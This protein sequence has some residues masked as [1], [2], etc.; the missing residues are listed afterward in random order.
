ML[1][2]ARL[3][4]G[5]VHLVLDRPVRPLTVPHPPSPPSPGA[6]GSKNN[7][8]LLLPTF[9]VG[10]FY[11]L[12][13]AFCFQNSSCVILPQSERRGRRCQ[14]ERKVEEGVRGKEEGGEG[15]RGEQEGGEGVKGEQEGGGS[16]KGELIQRPARKLLLQ[17]SL[18][19]GTVQKLFKVLTQNSTNT[20]IAFSIDI[21]VE[22]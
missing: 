5:S 8:H 16:V 11:Y 17:S 18:P 14:S 7:P 12:N 10:T 20:S 9:I 21:F 22:H 15:V 3:A 13:I 2:V 19:R 1:C 6:V 4:E